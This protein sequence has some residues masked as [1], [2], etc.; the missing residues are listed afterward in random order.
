[1]TALLTE[2]RGGGLGRL[3]TTM[4][5][6]LLNSP[7]ALALG[8]GLGTETATRAAV[9]QILA[10]RKVPAVLDADGLNAFSSERRPRLRLRAGR[11][12]LVLTPH[13]GEAA[14]L[15]GT[16]SAAIQADRLGSARRLAAETGAVVVLKG[17]RTIVADPD[18]RASF[19]SSGNPG[20]ATAGTGDAL[21]GVVGALL[22]RGLAGFDAA[23]LGT[24]VHGAAGDLASESFGQDGM[25]AGDLIDALPAAWRTTADRR[26]G[27]DRW[28]PGA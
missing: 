22:A 7:D 3:S 17:R 23:R 13:P 21:T 10:T 6:E 19:N 20:M 12:P 24:Y 8:P 18:G 28:T 9:V 26:R 1:M 16:T 4:V 5:R 15:L 2:T 27:V 25:I 14:R 11:H